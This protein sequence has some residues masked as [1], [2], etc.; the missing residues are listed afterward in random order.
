MA[1]FSELGMGNSWNS[2]AA[3]LTEG[4]LR[5]DVASTGIANL[6]RGNNQRQYRHSLC[7]LELAESFSQTNTWIACP[8]AALTLSLPASQQAERSHHPERGTGV[9]ETNQK[10]GIYHI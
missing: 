3:R 7:N 8:S 5:M 9:K 4:D 10:H 1:N 2:V 6:T